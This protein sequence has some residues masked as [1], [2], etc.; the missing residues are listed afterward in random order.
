[1][2]FK[3]IFAFLLAAF[4]APCLFSCTV[5]RQQP[6]ED[7]TQSLKQE[8]AISFRITWKDYSGRGQAIWKIV[9]TYNQQSEQ[10]AVVQVVSGDEDLDAIGALL[11]TEQDMVFVLPY[12]YV[13]Y[14]GSLGLLTDLTGSFTQEE[15]AFYPKVWEL[16]KADGVTYGIP[17]LGHSMCLLYNKTLLKKADVD[18][19]SITS[20]DALADAMTIIEEKTEAK[21]IGLVGADSNDVSWM[22][23]QFIYGF[24][25]KLVNEA[26]DRV[27]INSPESI[28][29]IEYYRDVLG[30]HA[31]SSWTIDTG[32]EV[33]EH[34]LKQEVAFEIQGIWG[35]TDV[36][37]NGSPFEV[38][39]IPLKQIGICSEI[40]P[41]MLVIPKNM[42][43]EAKARA[44]DFIR[45]MISMD[46]QEAILNGEFSPEHDAYYPFRTPIRDDMADTQ[47]L[48]M[49]PVYQVFIEGF[50]NPSI[51]VPVPKWQTI[52]KELYEPGLHSVMIGAISVETFLAMIET[53]GN[54]ILNG[55]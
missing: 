21:G 24:G 50:E 34:F 30:A 40:G 22:V 10:D 20:L 4:V 18:P 29:A 33:M 26:G 41:M 53:N 47:M 32:V 9:D 5:F 38:G 14:F 8:K 52:K 6:V 12:R 55:E 44:T 11:E 48:R 3:R 7:E 42:S 45:Y 23:N 39:V 25:G 13:A 54:Q 35:V 49:N 17:W 2:T 43:D 19:A 15:N 1:M 46:A 28:A 27:A 37:K 31:P 51:D 36:L 16:G